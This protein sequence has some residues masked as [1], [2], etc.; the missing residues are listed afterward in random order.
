MIGRGRAGGLVPG[1]PHALRLA[2]GPVTI[3]RIR[4]A[5]PVTIRPAM[6]LIR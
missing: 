1:R 3:R 2:V 4:P 6:P 5:G